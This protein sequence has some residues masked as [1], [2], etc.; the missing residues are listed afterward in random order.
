M[1]Y[2]LRIQAWK[3]KSTTVHSQLPLW[4]NEQIEEAWKL[5]RITLDMWQWNST[6]TT[7]PHEAEKK[8]EDSMKQAANKF[9]TLANEE[10]KKRWI[11]FSQLSSDG[12]LHK[13]W[14]FL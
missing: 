7:V 6:F 14:K 9:K 8:Y 13:F 4:W 5:K 2:K 3:K 10:K 11:E 1:L 12:A